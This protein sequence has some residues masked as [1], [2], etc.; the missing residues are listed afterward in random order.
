MKTCQIAST[1]EEKLLRAIFGEYDNC[2]NRALP[3]SRLCLRHW[4]ECNTHGW[5]CKWCW[6][7]RWQVITDWWRGRN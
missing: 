1:P 2:P 7:E 6:E 3:F 5:F 4:W